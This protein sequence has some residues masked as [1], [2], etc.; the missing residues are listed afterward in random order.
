[1][2]FVFIFFPLLI[3]I[4][5]IKAKYNDKIHKFHYDKNILFRIDKIIT[6][7]SN[8][9]SSQTKEEKNHKKWENNSNNESSQQMNQI[10]F[11]Q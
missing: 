5:A 7:Y 8:C 10:S 1:M 6:F 4:F 11:C 2:S 9:Y 3:I